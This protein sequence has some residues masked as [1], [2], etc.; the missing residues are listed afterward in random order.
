MN[1]L[2]SRLYRVLE[3][4]TNFLYLNL[5]WLVCCVPVV[6]IPSSTAAMF[7]VVREWTKQ[8]E[9]G[10]A[11]TF[12]AMFRDNFRQS[13]WIGFLWAIIGAVLAV[14]LAVVRGMGPP[15]REILY[16]LVFLIGFLYAFA[17][18]YLFPVMVNFNARWT[19][20]VRNALLFSVGSPITTLLCLIVFGAAV[21]AF[22]FL[23]VS[24]FVS[25]SITACLVYRLCDRTFEKVARL[26]GSKEE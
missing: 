14:D 6:T 10:V 8:R 23:P 11:G 4:C 5:L 17:S 19:D 26:K 16:V 9:S 2:E 18:V 7:G 13:L 12:L 21:L 3:V 20:V 24:I 15:V 22:L 1:I 25:G